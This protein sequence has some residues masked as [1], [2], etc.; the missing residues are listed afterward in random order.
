MGSSQATHSR[1]IRFA[2]AGFAAI[3][4]LLLA[5]VLTAHW[6]HSRAMRRSDAQYVSISHRIDAVAELNEVIAT[7]HAE[8]QQVMPR[9]LPQDLVRLSVQAVEADRRFSEVGRK[10]LRHPEPDPDANVLHDYFR[11]TAV[12][13]LYFST[14]DRVI[15]VAQRGDG[16]E[17]RVLQ[18]NA[19]A[20]MRVRQAVIAARLLRQLT[21]RSVALYGSL[22]AARRAEARVE[23]VANL[24]VLGLL[25]VVR[26]LVMARLKEDSDQGERNFALL[27]ER[28]RDLDD[29]AHRV[30]H[31]LKGLVNPITGYASLI[32]ESPDDAVR[33]SRY[34]ERISRKTDEVV[35]MVDELLHLARAGNVSQGPSPLS[36]VTNSVLEQ[37]EAEVTRVEASFSV[38]I[39]DVLV[40]VGEVPLREVIQNLVQNSLKYRCA[41]RALEIS[42]DARAGDELVELSV[43]DNGLGMSGEVIEHAHEPFFRANP[44]RDIAGSGLGLAVVSRIVVAHGGSFLIESDEGA[45]T[46]VTVT[47]PRWR[48]ATT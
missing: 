46:T 45:G 32:A 9:T 24:A 13:R 28:N 41:Q 29:F 35:A 31:D 47:L 42:I 5:K 36:A 27:A 22:G 30:A 6:L 11:M 39:P 38:S 4:L 12:T 33:V 3:A 21:H 7:I 16:D 37:F 15:A 44:Q 8:V 48:A 2:E 40:N 10:F 25:L 18:N 1:A 17:A 23:L 20:P 19:L 43:H 14:L 34:A 26:R